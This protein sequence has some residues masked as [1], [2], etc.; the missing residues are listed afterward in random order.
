MAGRAISGEAGMV[1]RG[2]GQPIIGAMTI[3][4]LQGCYYM[5]RSFA[6]GQ[7]AVVAT[8]TNTLGLRTVHSARR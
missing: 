5:Q 3:V 2:S 4:T 1:R 8:G 7:H 6:S